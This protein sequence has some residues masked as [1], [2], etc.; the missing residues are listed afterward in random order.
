MVQE[1]IWF[2]VK[3]VKGSNLRLT[4]AKAIRGFVHHAPLDQLNLLFSYKA[5]KPKAGTQRSRVNFI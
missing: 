2:P 1:L 3:G 5:L 4:L